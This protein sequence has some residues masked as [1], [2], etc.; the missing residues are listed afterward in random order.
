MITV[1]TLGPGSPDLLTAESAQKLQNGNLYFR[2][3]EKPLF[4]RRGH[5]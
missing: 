2:T 1:L 3:A 5:E 4:G